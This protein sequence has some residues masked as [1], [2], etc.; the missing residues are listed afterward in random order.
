MRGALRKDEHEILTVRRP[1]PEI[2]S[3]L[4]PRPLRASYRLQMHKEFPLA[5]AASIAGYLARLGISHVYLSPILEAR[6][7]STHGY[8]VASHGRVNRELGG[9]EGWRAFVDAAHREGVGVLID[10][11]PNHMGIGPTN[12]EWEDVLARGRRS[13]FAH[14][15]DIDWDAPPRALTG[16]VLV[17][18]LAEE[19]DV[20]IDRGELALLLENDRPRVGFSGASYP[21][22]EE[23]VA[24]LATFAS[25]PG[26]LTDQDLHR[27]G[28]GDEGR[29]RL[30]ALLDDQYYRLVHWRRAPRELNYRRFFD[31]NDLI[32]LRAEDERVFQATHALPLRWVAAGDVDALRVDHIDGLADPLA[33]LHRLREAT[34]GATP[35]LVEKIVSS[36]ETLRAEWPVAGTTG[37]EFMN[38]LE[39]IF[40]DPAGAARIEVDYR[41]LVRIRGDGPTFRQVGYQGKVTLLRSSLAPDV[42]RLARLLAPIARDN[43]PTAGLARGE[44]V[45]AIVQLCAR[46]PVYRTYVRASPD[47]GAPDVS[48]GDRRLIAQTVAELRER[49][50]IAPRLLEL[51]EAILSFAHWESLSADARSQRVA[52][53]TRW[54]QTT[55]PATAKGVEDTA[56]YLYVPL[57]SRNEVGGDPGRSVAD[58]CRRLHDGNAA[59]AR[60]WPHTLLSTNTHDTKRSADVRARLDVLSEIPDEWMRSVHRW[61]RAHAALRSKGSGPAAPDANAEYLLYQTLL[62]V[63]PVTGDGGEPDARA[64]DALRERVEAYMLKAVREA[65]TRSSWTEPN[66]AYESALTRYLGGLLD[67]ARSAGFLSEMSALAAR[68]ATAGM[69]NAVARTLVHLTSPGVPDI[70]QGDELWHMA[71]V[72][73]DNR[74]PV[75]FTHR[76][77]LLAGLPEAADESELSRLVTSPVDG[78]LKLH[79]TTAAL[80]ARRDHASLFSQGS[81][82]PLAVAGSLA[83]HVFAFARESTHDGDGPH[84]SAAVT[85]VPRLAYTMAGGA[86]PIGELWGDTVVHLPATWG[87]PRSLTS[88]LDGRRIERAHSDAGQILRVPDA[89]RVLPVALLIAESG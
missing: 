47:G 77:R 71:L 51:L 62:G 57:V 39:E 5:A 80:R 49:N 78:R 54:Q 66:T 42:R 43:P 14:W 28:D 48:D 60:H 4:S 1:S 17:P 46:L 12:A 65:K 34:G 11:V 40:L 81:Y 44:L 7:G 27:F 23:S 68:I 41:R 32:A 53:V 86:A 76:D 56:L 18:T 20:M 21:L 10:I 15:F 79:V 84:P 3:P 82:R 2:M 31:I 30:R 89:L 16:R 87:Q 83:G 69:W 35:V 73:P 59:R 61:R 63:W 88:A 26:R 67:P 13:P 38:D 45:E 74:R 36:G 19:R 58:A 29:A 6:P 75:D 72:D 55:G 52:F 70:Y 50:D 37:Y 9:D 8:D 24:T 22:R 33:Y 85:I 64:L 25:S